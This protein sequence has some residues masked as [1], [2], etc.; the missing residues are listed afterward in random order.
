MKLCGTCKQEK[1]VSE[2]NKKDKIRLQN[3]CRDCQKKYYKEYY[4]REPKEK[5]RILIKNHQRRNEIKDF[6][7]SI[8]ESNPC[9][10]CE[11]YYP[12]CVMDFD[13]ID[14]NKE[15]SIAKM[16][17]SLRPTSTIV[18]EINKCELVCSNCHRIRTKNRLI[19]G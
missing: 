11:N 15:A 5:E 13:H 14:D 12:A 1:P 7:N 6:I 4:R 8:K 19:A 2:F 18:K 9:M 10:D 3:K 16:V 17:S